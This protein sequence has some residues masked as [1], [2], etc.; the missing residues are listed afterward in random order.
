MNVQDYIS[1]GIIESYVLDLATSGERVEFER[2]CEEYPELSEARE[3]FE[4]SLEIFALAHAASAPESIKTRFLEAVQGSVSLNQ[5]KIAKGMTVEKTDKEY[6]PLKTSGFLRFMAAASVI[7]LI[8][9]AYLSYRYYSQN[10]LL[11]HSNNELHARLNSSDSLLN[12]IAGE[13]KVVSDP[14]VTIVNL[15]GTQATPKSSANI[16]WD[17]A[18][19][20]VYL[21]VR[22]MPELPT[23]KQYQLWALIDGKPKDLGVFNMDKSRFILKMKNT[24]KA[25]AFA[26]TIEQKGGSPSPTLE[27][28]QSLGKLKMM[29]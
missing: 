26:I 25:D 3:K 14:N 23:D 21:V 13:Q 1:S 15:V 7:L 19:A 12:K 24:R 17:S 9:C 16:Y 4:Y 18:S 22:N 29:Q 6:R 27:K 8:G 28:M 10:L 2:F 11:V 5:T 20:N